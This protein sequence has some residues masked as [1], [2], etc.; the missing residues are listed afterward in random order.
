DASMVNGIDRSTR[1]VGSV[2]CFYTR[3]SNHAI[4]TVGQGCCIRWPVNLAFHSF[5][6][7]PSVPV[8]ATCG[9]RLNPPTE[10][11]GHSLIY[12]GKDLDCT[13]WRPSRIEDNKRLRFVTEAWEFIYSQTH[14]WR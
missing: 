12:C 2:L 4:A 13:I 14:D 7:K 3:F 10:Q 6:N 9:I 5:L 8:R 11:F 1:Q